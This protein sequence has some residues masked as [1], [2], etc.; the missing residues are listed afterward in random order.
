MDIMISIVEWF[1]GLLGLQYAGYGP[2]TAIFIG[3]LIVAVS[4]RVMKFFFK[5]FVPLFQTAQELGEA[6]PVLDRKGVRQAQ[7]AD[8]FDDSF[9]ILPDE[10]TALLKPN[11]SRPWHETET[12]SHQAGSS[13]SRFDQ[14][15]SMDLASDK[16]DDEDIADAEYILEEFK[17]DIPVLANEFQDT[18][19]TEFDQPINN[20][21]EA[22]ESAVEEDAA[23]ERQPSRLARPAPKL[24]L[25][26]SQKSILDGLRNTPTKK[27]P[28]VASATLA[29]SNGTS[30]L[31]PR[32]AARDEMPLVQ[33]ASFGDTN[34]PASAINRLAMRLGE[35]VTESLA[36]IPNL[37]VEA[38]KEP[39]CAA[40]EI[41][42]FGTRFVVEGGI[43]VKDQ[44]VVAAIK[45]KNGHDGTEVLSRDMTC[46]PSELQK[47][48]KEVALE[49]AAAVIAHQ[50]TTGA[51][52]SRHLGSPKDVQSGSRYPNARR[53]LPGRLRRTDQP[54]Q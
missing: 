50:Q 48:E 53:P 29:V 17:Q 13:Q 54:V 1:N 41:P 27:P 12:V 51:S 25:V 37:A 9:G 15:C 47:F 10:P 23:A 26:S 6:N 4:L 7:L 44:G 35:G 16:G 31:P 2:I 11:A 18:E 52:V 8:T 5:P 49:I 34:Q 39:T 30:K 20:F 3:L 36:R 28:A 42:G 21:S 33:I 40:A 24:S 43:E 38:S 14:L 45:V 32:P 19:E 22:L 46:K